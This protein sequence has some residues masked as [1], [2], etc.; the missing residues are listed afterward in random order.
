MKLDQPQPHLAPA[1]GMP[2]TPISLKFPRE[3]CEV[4]PYF[5]AFKLG[6]GVVALPT[7]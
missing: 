7:G 1:R 4:L 2:E 3:E 5:P 6:S